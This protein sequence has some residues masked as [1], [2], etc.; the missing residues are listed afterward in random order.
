MWKKEKE[1][2]IQSGSTPM[3]SEVLHILQQEQDTGTNP[4]Q[5][6]PDRLSDTVLPHRRS[7]S[8]I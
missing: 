6:C 3:I 2:S 8:A 1:G 4:I 7:T 5:Q